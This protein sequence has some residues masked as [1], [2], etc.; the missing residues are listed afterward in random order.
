MVVSGR[1][2]TR[3][4][5]LR[6]PHISP[7]TTRGEGACPVHLA[8]LPNVAQAGL[9]SGPRYQTITCENVLQVA[10]I[11]AIAAIEFFQ[12][13]NRDRRQVSPCRSRH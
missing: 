5:V 6:L 8:L 10:K 11:Y 13:A 1:S 3:S 9:A 12:R 2:I 4:K 7:R